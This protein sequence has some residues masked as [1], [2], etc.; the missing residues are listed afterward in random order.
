M[1]F[2]CQD[3]RASR[4]A[5][6]RDR[7]EGFLTTNEGMNLQVGAAREHKSR[8][9]RG[10]VTPEERNT[11]LPVSVPNAAPHFI[12]PQKARRTRNSNS[13]EYESRNPVISHLLPSSE[14]QKKSPARRNEVPSSEP[15]AD[16]W[17]R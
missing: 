3:N 2:C 6:A 12:S 17:G 7:T 16:I 9:G 10:E 4:K 1:S 13:N 8:F 14:A 11:T 5:G 15:A